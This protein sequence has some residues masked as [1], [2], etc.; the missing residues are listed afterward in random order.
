MALV[1]RFWSSF[2]AILASGVAFSVAC[3]GSTAA[4][5]AP[6]KGSTNAL[7]KESTKQFEPEPL[8]VPETTGV[9]EE[10]CEDGR[11]VRAGQPVECSPTC[12]GHWTEIRRCIG[13]RWNI[14]RFEAD[15]SLCPSAL[16]PDLAGCALEHTRLK[17]SEQSVR[18]GCTLSLNCGSTEVDVTC[19]GENDDTN[20]SL[21]DCTRDGVRDEHALKN[22]YQGEA[23]DSCLAAAVHCRAPRTRSQKLAN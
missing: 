4:P 13:G 15:C 23:P 8:L 5:G 14:K 21:C 22:L 16:T 10:T 9:L 17:A 20:T 1:W 7:S 18:D 3:G 6:S 2:P 12:S 11:E 19:D